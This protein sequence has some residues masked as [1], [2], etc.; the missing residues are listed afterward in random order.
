MLKPRLKP[1]TKYEINSSHSTPSVLFTYDAL[2]KMDAFIQTCPT[3]VG[4]LGYVEHFATENLYYVTDVEL[5]KQNASAATTEI[6]PET[7]SSFAEELLARDN[8][9]ELWNSLRLWGHSHVNMGVTPSGQDD[10]QMKVFSANTDYFI[11]VIGN[12]AGEMKVDV[13]DFTAGINCLDVVWNVETLEIE[14]SPIELELEAELAE[15]ERLYLASIKTLV[16]QKS[17]MEKENLSTITEYTSSITKVVK[18][19]VKKKVLPMHAAT[20]NY[21]GVGRAFQEK[22]TINLPERTKIEPTSVTKDLILSTFT[23][24]DIDILGSSIESRIKTE[25]MDEYGYDFTTFPYNSREKMYQ[26]IKSEKMVK[27]EI[28]LVNTRAMYPQYGYYG[29]Q[30]YF[31][32]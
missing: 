13:Y 3:E 9:V 27:E 30:G 4:W 23:Q 31:D 10:S 1:T 14:K 19:D 22:K 29:R 15:R 16:E 24:E 12:K 21:Y 8:G 5:F 6:Q 18:E 7:L 17:A 32:Y 11:R 28:N 25:I 2:A 26:I 20:R